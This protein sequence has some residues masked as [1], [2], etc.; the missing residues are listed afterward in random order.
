MSSLSAPSAALPGLERISSHSHD[1]GPRQEPPRAVLLAGVTEIDPGGLFVLSRLADLLRAAAEGRHDKYRLLRRVIVIPRTL[2]PC[3]EGSREKLA[4]ALA[5]ATRSVFFRIELLGPDAQTWDLPQVQL[6]G[7]SHE[8]REGGF[9]IGLPAI[10][11]R[12]PEALPGH[13]IRRGWQGAVGESFLLRG[14]EPGRLHLGNCQSLYQGLVRLLI[15]REILEGELPD[16]DEDPQLFPGGEAIPVQA[17]GAGLFATHLSP[18][19]W[20]LAG[21]SLGYL[22]D[23]FDG[24]VVEELK[25]PVSGLVSSLCLCP[26]VEAGGSLLRILVRGRGAAEP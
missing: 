20:V 9:L 14:G 17:E 18:G 23:P 15:H 24:R 4:E 21:E 2:Q 12:A 19:R 6:F 22:H 26:L 11:D 7:S 5:E 8:E 10:L 3:F 16:G 13:A 25:A 1:L